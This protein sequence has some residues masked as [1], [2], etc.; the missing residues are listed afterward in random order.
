VQPNNFFS[1]DQVIDRQPLT[2]SPQTPLIEVISLMQKWG[3]SCSFTDT[4][5]TLETDATIGTNNSC[6]LIVEN[7]QLRGI[8]TERDLVK[9]IATGANTE[10][11]TVNEVGSQNLVAL[12]ATGS[13]DIFAALSMLRQHRIRHLPIV[14][15]R[16]NLLGLITAKNLR[17]K[18]QPIN[19]MQW[20]KVSEVIK[21]EV[22]HAAP[23]D[24][25]RHIA[26]LMADREISC[27]AIAESELDPETNSSLVRPVGIITERDIVQFQNLNLDLE[28]SACNLMSAPLFLIG[29]DDTLWSVHQQMQQRRVRR[30]LVG[31]A[32]GE[33]QGIIT[34]TSLLQLFDPMEMYEV[35]DV[36]QRQVCQLELEKTKLLEN[37]QAELENEVREQTAALE[38]TN[39]QLQSESNLRQQSQQRFDNILNS[40]EDV[41]YSIV[42][43]TF[44]ILYLNSAVEKIY[45]RQ[46]GEFYDNPH[47]C[48]EV[49]HPEDRDRVLDFTQNIIET[50]ASE[51]EYRIV[52]PDG[53][54]RWLRDRACLTRDPEG[55]PIRLD[56]IV[57]DISDRQRREEILKDIASGISVEIGANFLPSLV[58]YLSQTLKVDYAF[59]G[60]LIG[61]EADSIKT[62]AVYG[63][64][65]TIDNFE[66]NLANSPCENVIKQGLCVYSE[67]VRQLF[68]EIR[69]LEDMEAESYAGM[70]IFNAAGKIVGLISIVDSKPFNNIS[71]IEEVLKIFATR[72]T[73]ELERQQAEADLQKSNRLLQA[74]SWI[75]TQFLA[76]AES[77][78]LF[79][80]MLDHVLSLTESEYGFIGEILFASDGSPMMEEGYMKFRGR[81]YLKT[82]AITN[83]AWNE[84]TRAFY[85]ENA[86][87]GMEFHNLQTLFGAVIVTGKP[88]IANSPSTDPRRGGLPDGHPPLNAFLGVPF[89]KNEQM[90]GMVGIANR[91][92]GYDEAMVDYLQP[93]LATCSCIIEAYRSERQKQQAEQKIVE[94]AALLN[95]ATDA[96]MVRELDN[97]ILFWNQGA[98]KLYGWTQAE[99]IKRD[100]NKLLYRESLTELKAIQQAVREKGQW[101]GELNQVTKTGKN[102]LVES[103]WTLVKDKAGNP[104]SFLVVNTDITEQKQLEAQFLRT[105]R[106]ES[107]GTLAGGIA[108]KEKLDKI[109]QPSLVLGLELLIFRS[110]QAKR[111]TY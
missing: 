25:V 74:I 41:I 15:D 58:K 9:L 56:G 110:W 19:L 23:D 55:T 106:L 91:E 10:N 88:V 52:R 34:Q 67:A 49:V 59:V 2:V 77:E 20:R 11:V 43:N 97:Q 45:G 39:Q 75:Q 57:T 31:G 40:L 94:Q 60:E 95:V 102:I 85:A 37:R 30:L 93:F 96:I 63:Q 36:L 53:E 8:F 71:L 21:T 111:A 4:E 82:H 26:R 83:I 22:I 6:V 109:G 98:E 18:L 92:G 104:Q 33:L 84:E 24:S 42:P 29:P 89:S 101:Q 105:Q 16:Q 99:V 12:T 65:K 27:V 72:A 107:L 5:V 76:D 13:E 51:I 17:Q 68:P 103:R 47:L 108:P 90:T 79:D 46:I 100:A 44:D 81:P 87:K 1:L 78:I 69:P 73:I 28:Q 54:I 3:N 66:Y 50:E 48:F 62:L 64:G 86:P 80:G 35:I 61:L 38:A 70:P 14:D 7:S 32:R